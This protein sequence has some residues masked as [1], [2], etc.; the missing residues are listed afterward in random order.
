MTEKMMFEVLDKGF[1][2]LIDFMGS[3]LRAVEAARVSF[4]K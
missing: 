3:D 4:Q 2:E 1:I